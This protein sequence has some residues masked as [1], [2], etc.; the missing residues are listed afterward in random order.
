MI[1]RIALVILILITSFTLFSNQITL[2]NAA[3]LSLHTLTPPV[4]EPVTSFT[5]KISGHVTYRFLGWFKGIKPQDKVK[6][7]PHVTII[8]RNIFTKQ[9]FSTTTNSN[10]DYILEAPVGK[11]LVSARNNRIPFIPGAKY[12]NLKNDVSNINFQGLT[13]KFLIQ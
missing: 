11:Y 2:A 1:L 6:P 12:I 13:H 9:K 5:K 7:A 4:T 8:A 10:G 3:T